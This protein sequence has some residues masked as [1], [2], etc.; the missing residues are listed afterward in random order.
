[1][2]NNQKKLYREKLV[3]VAIKLYFL[4]VVGLIIDGMG[5]YEIY[6]NNSLN[7]KS[8]IELLV[9][10]L[11]IIIS[12]IKMHNLRLLENKINIDEYESRRVNVL[13]INGD[14][15]KLQDTKDELNISEYKISRL[16][17]IIEVDDVTTLVKFKDSKKYE[18]VQ[19]EYMED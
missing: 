8:I 1:M 12:Y 18:L 4:L 7:N 19:L 3:S 5:L 16:V 13:G 17:G 10:T 15:Y 2:N 9:A 6:K 11:I 14:I